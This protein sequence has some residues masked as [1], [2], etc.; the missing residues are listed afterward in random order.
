MNTRDLINSSI[1]FLFII[2][3]AML[4][5]KIWQICFMSTVF[6]MFLKILHQCHLD[7]LIDEIKV[8]FQ[9]EN[10]AG[11]ILKLPIQIVQTCKIY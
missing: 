6:V 9:I 3:M 1:F 11:G 10:L 7:F 4:Q 8:K 2:N 5:N